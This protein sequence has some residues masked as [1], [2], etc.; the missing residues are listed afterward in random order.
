MTAMQIVRKI[1]RRQTTTTTARD[2]ALEARNQI[3]RD[4]I[5]RLAPSA[6]EIVIDSYQRAYPES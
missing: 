1:A 4:A 5:A 2:R 3:I 6:Q